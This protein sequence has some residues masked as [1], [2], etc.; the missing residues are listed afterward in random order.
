MV[1]SDRIWTAAELEQLSP[2]VRHKVS[3]DRVAVDLTEVSPE[4]AERARARGRALLEA[5]KVTD[6]TSA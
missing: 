1:D 5:R 6:T 4:F 3:N 2:D